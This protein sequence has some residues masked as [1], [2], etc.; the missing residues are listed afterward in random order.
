MQTLPIFLITAYCSRNQPF[1]IAPL[2]QSLALSSHPS[3]ASARLVCLFCAMERGEETKAA[4]Y[5]PLDDGAEA[6]LDEFTRCVRLEAVGQKFVNGVSSRYDDE[7]PEQLAGKVS[8]K[9][10]LVCLLALL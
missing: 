9:S 6:V 5:R 7:Y 4:A 10:V 8:A 1:P 3:T 2:E